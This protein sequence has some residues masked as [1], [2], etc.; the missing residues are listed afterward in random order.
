MLC[1]LEIEIYACFFIM[2]SQRPLPCGRK[3]KFLFF[4]LGNK[5]IQKYQRIF[6]WFKFPAYTPWCLASQPFCLLLRKSWQDMF[7]L[8]LCRWQ[9]DIYSDK[10]FPYPQKTLEQARMKAQHVIHL[11]THSCQLSFEM[12]RLSGLASSCSWRRAEVL[13]QALYHICQPPSDVWNTSGHFKYNQV[14]AQI[15]GSWPRDAPSVFEPLLL[16]GRNLHLSGDLATELQGEDGCCH[17]NLDI[18]S[19]RL[20]PELDFSA[21]I[22]VSESLANR[23]W[24]LNNLPLTSALLFQLKHPLPLFWLH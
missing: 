20:L 16:S 1:L 7:V 3:I 2:W 10:I 24:S 15:S 5:S 11:P 4:S 8:L 19:I 9:G 6:P 18:H 13:S 23:A 22:M 12:P 21:F 14:P 17:P